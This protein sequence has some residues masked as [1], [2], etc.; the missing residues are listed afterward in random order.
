[1]DLVQ[2]QCPVENLTA[3]GADQALADR[4]HPRRLHR[5]THDGGAGGLKDGVEGRG[6][7]RAGVTDQEPEAP[8]PLAEV[9]SQ[10]A[11]LL[12]RPLAPTKS[13]CRARSASSTYLGK[14]AGDMSTLS[15][16][17]AHDKPR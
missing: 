10:V 3:L 11:G 13:L 2:D 6:E 14:D 16:G 17:G 1:M 15:T 5:A 8:E 4:V 7:I 12:H 9:E